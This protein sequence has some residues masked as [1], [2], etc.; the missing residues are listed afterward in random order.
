MELNEWFS[1]SDGAELSLM[2]RASWRRWWL[3][4]GLE[5]QLGVD[6]ADNWEE[7]YF[8]RMV[9]KIYFIGFEMYFICCCCSVNKSCPTVCNPMNCSTPC[10]PFL[11][12]LPEFAQL[13]SVESVMPSN[14]LIFC[15][16][17]IFGVKYR[18]LKL[19]K[20]KD[21]SPL[22]KN[23]ETLPWR[24]IFK[25]IMGEMSWSV[26][27]C[28]HFLL[29]IKTSPLGLKSSACLLVLRLWNFTLQQFFRSLD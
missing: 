1:H 9:I 27:T 10:F 20:L 29:R 18:S 25:K 7:A 5:G 26:P 3:K 21:I 17:L 19:W 12:C 24:L 13:M 8:K 23:I 15:C 2:G 22:M 6:L 16:F 14:Q 4:W 28:F 11:H